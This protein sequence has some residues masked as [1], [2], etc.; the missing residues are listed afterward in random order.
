VP[1]A[2]N[3]NKSA[4]IN[5]AA[6]YG[7]NCMIKT[8][9]NLTDVTIDYYV[10]INFKGVVALVNSLGGIDV[11]VDEPDY[12]KNDG[13]A[14]G[15]NTICEQ[16]S[17]RE[18]GN[19][20]VY[21]K[22]GKNVHLNGEQALAY[23]RDRHQWALS[24]FKRIAHQQAVVTAIVQKAKTIRNVNTFY[25]VL[26]AVSNNIDT[27]MATDQMLNFY[28][29]GKNVLTNSNFG[30][31]EFINVQKTFLS[32]YDLHVFLNGMDTYTFQYYPESL[33]EITTAMKENLEIKK[34]KM[35][36]TFNFSANTEY[37]IPTIGTSFTAVKRNETLPDFT[38]S[39][40]NY[41]ESWAS[42]RSITINKNYVEEN[43]C[44]N[45]SVIG[46]DTHYGT[47][48]A[49]LNSLTV[50]ICKNSETSL[51]VVS[52]SKETTTTSVTTTK[53]NDETT[54]TTETTTTKNN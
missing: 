46:Q 41:V 37:E 11:D 28:N 48:V 25:K 23:S 52:E 21:I 31:G 32:G 14:C 27:N 9:Q 3:N 39:S 20:T 47:L 34:P 1:I 7:T 30:E 35:I 33:N 43:G 18:F 8:I 13:I 2:C 49:S 6:A 22:P 51:P 5:S 29:V 44:T 12:S 4:K 45:D 38:G 15:E 40:I 50:N 36:K 24:D 19:N 54:T 26:N 10:K 53:N 42:S 17:N 16:N